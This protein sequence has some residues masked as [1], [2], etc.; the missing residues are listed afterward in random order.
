MWRR[1]L[2]IDW[3]TVSKLT[4]KFGSICCPKIMSVSTLAL[5][6]RMVTRLAGADSNLSTTHALTYLRSS[7][8]LKK[9]PQTY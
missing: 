9:I 2:E 7:V 1:P 3:I 6:R 8:L 4:I 5:I